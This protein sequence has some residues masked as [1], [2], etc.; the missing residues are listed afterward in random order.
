MFSQGQYC[1]NKSLMP[2]EERTRASAL[3]ELC[4]I[5]GI[6]SEYND[7]WGKARRASDRTRCAALKALGVL[8]RDDDLRGALDAHER[9]TWSRIVPPVAVFRV[10]A[11]PYRMRFRFDERHARETYGWR[12]QLEDGDVH[13]GVFR[14]EQLEVLRRHAIATQTWREVAFDWND[15]L[16]CGYHRYELEGPGLAADSHVDFIVGPRCCYVPPA[17]EN[18][19][20]VWGPAV[21][22]Y[23]LRSHRSWGMGDL[24]DLRTLIAQWGGR[25]AGVIGLNP[26][27]ALFPHNPAHAS[28]YSPSSRLFLNV[29]YID[30]SAVPDAL[31]ATDVLATIGSE[32]FQTA[33]RRA[34]D[35]ELVD[36]PAVAKL[37]FPPLERLY[38][39]FRL[40]HLT[41]QT[42]RGKAFRRFQEA[43]GSRLAR[44]TL[45]EALQEYFH[46]KDSK[47]WGWPVWPER[48]RRPDAPDVLAFAQANTERIEFYQYLQWQ[49]AQQL[50]RAQADAQALAMGVGIYLD[51]AISID[52]G[53]AESWANQQLYAVGASVGA[54]PDEVNLLG[55]NWGLPP[56]RPNAL[57]AERYEPF[58]ATL[59][60]N[61]RCSGALRIDHVMGL[62]R[63][64]WIPPGASAAE[65]AYVHYPFE[66]LLTILALESVRNA[67]MVIGE[68][69]GTVPDEVRD[70][71]QRARVMSYRV[72]YFERDAAGVYKPPEDYPVD[73]LVAVSTHD[74]ATLA[75]FWEG[76]DLEVRRALDLF[77]SE[78]VRL[79]YV[80]NRAVEIEQ[81]EAA[82]EREQLLPAKGTDIAART[83]DPAVAQ[84]IHSYLACT[85]SRLFVVQLEDVLGVREQANLPG[86]VEEQPNWRRRLP[87]ALE[88][89]ECDERFLRTA[90][91]LARLRPAGARSHT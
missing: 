87:L 31:E 28:P 12:F 29:L 66:D 19:G 61:M 67:C 13:T 57:E 30:V 71:L 17:L 44:H 46:R 88:E 60:A 6:A 21:Q 68:D 34:Q 72:L 90:E 43:G 56:L 54:P 50:E 25:G 2:D 38:R 4:R 80:A 11:A 20:R 83:L 18:G 86:T 85:P 42:D 76:H 23:S 9:N 84:A 53:G 70:G 33:L 69:L 62:Y 52:R 65:G 39:H 7:I 1:C 8:E 48:Y 77:P 79:E 82:L 59:R 49:A 32:A 89:L 27:H 55:Q 45:F 41:P 15:R 63:L 64:Y 5:H 26:L 75:G 73:A 47:V 10:D 24:G 37:K 51:L 14:P 16:P 36:Y 3:D 35:A 22:L 91:A 78:Q 40:R 58:I 74:L 81:L